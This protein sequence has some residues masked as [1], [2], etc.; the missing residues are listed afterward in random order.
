MGENK[1]KQEW[2]DQMDERVIQSLMAVMRGGAVVSGGV[3]SSEQGRQPP[4]P[5][6]QQLAPAPTQQQSHEQ[7]SGGDSGFGRQA[8][9][10]SL[11]DMDLSRPTTQH[12]SAVAGK[13]TNE[14]HHGHQ[15]PPSHQSH[16]P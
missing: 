13:R 14:Q 4:Q 7:S 16:Q 1:E 6:Q 3:A 11:M 2:P 10:P 12:Y 9:Q 8:Q 15:P 5:Q